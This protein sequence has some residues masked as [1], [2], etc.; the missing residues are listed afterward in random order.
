M[1]KELQIRVS[2][3]DG[4]D[5]NILKSISARKL[6]IKINRIVDIFIVRKSID[7]RRSNV[8]LN[9]SLGLYIDEKDVYK[10]F[11]P[12]Y[13]NVGDASPII[14]IGAG[15]AGLFAALRL[16]ERGFKPIVIERG[17]SVEERK[18]DLGKLYKTGI[19]NSN[20]NYSF[21]EGGAGTFSDG[22]LY[23]R[24]TKRGDVRRALEILVYHG[25]SPDILKESHPHIGTDKLPNVISNIRETIKKYG[26]EVYFDTLFTDFII[27]KGKCIGIIANDKEWYS[28]S[29][30]L[31]TGH[32]ARDVYSLLE[33]R[34]IHI[35]AKDFAVGMRLEHPQ[36]EIDCIQYHSSE[37]RGD[38]LP[39]AE[40]RFA[41]N[42]DGRG[43]YSFCMCP[44]GVIVPAATDV[45]QQVVNGMS[46]SSRGTAFANSAIVTSVGKNELEYL[47]YKGKLGGMR[48][49]E[50]LELKAWNYGG[51]NIYAPAQMLRDFI[52]GKESHNLPK[53]S[54][55]PGVISAPLHKILPSILS[56]KIANGVQIFGQKANG[57]LSD[58]AIFLGF[59]TRTSS[60]LRICRNEKTEHIEIK[61]IYPCGEGAGYSGGI[62]SSAMDG[63]KVAENIK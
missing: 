54:Y 25:A 21:G 20:S 19:V 13:K 63:E 52:S 35:E 30:I 39:P 43:I 34:N 26:G 44:G 8:Q 1:Y 61:G 46:A 14:I 10:C 59:E 62:I 40:Y 28:S 60:P 58:N 42:I 4:S 53:T 38:Y 2:P 18:K 45:N 50:D 36:F 6:G 56:E 11:V 9:L 23:T 15:P 49:Q 7:A 48:F 57:F 24:A 55:K 32:S 33:K 29:V 47:N 51:G 5:I 16:I 41:T 31:A 12:S 27:E 37:G 3:K 17:K 22:K